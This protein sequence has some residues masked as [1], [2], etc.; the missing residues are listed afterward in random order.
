MKP[1][2]TKPRLTVL[3]ETKR[4]QI[5]AYCTLEL[6]CFVKPNETK[7]DETKAYCTLRNQTKPNQGLLYI[8]KPNETKRKLRLIEAYCTLGNKANE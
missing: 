3:C 4:N 6:P 5:K 1:N 2:E 7:R 8:A